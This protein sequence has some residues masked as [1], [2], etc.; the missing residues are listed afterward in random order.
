MPQAAMVVAEPPQTA[1]IIPQTSTKKL[2]PETTMK[3]EIIKP[4][5]S[6]AKPVENSKIAPVKAFDR[7]PSEQMLKTPI[8][9][10]TPVRTK[11][12]TNIPVRA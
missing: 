9:E 1:L 12:A 2:T 3:P 5:S 8:K 11:S 6:F 10:P 7:R 4:L